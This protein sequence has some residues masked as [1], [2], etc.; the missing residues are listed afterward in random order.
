MLLSMTN[1]ERKTGRRVLL[2]AIPIVLLIIGAYYASG[3]YRV[4]TDQ[5]IVEIT[6][7]DNKL[8][9]PKDPYREIH[10]QNSRNGKQYLIEATGSSTQNSF[11]TRCVGL[12]KFK[13]GQRI[14]ISLPEVRSL[15][16][17]FYTVLSSCYKIYDPGAPWYHFGTKE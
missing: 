2:L 12:P 6:Y 1:R 9:D 3:L 16:N 10:A 15:S 17:E 4:K 8:K 11:D 13:Q 5:V 7:D 14:K